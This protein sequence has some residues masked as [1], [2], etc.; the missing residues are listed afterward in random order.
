MGSAGTFE[1]RMEPERAQVSVSSLSNGGIK[2]DSAPE[3]S[4]VPF[5]FPFFCGFSR[6]PTDLYCHHQD[7]GKQAEKPNGANSC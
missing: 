6:R 1:V 3:F 4:L 2:T 5:P 7:Y